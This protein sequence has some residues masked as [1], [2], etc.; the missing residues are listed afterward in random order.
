MQLGQEGKAIRQI[1][2][3]LIMVLL[4]VFLAAPADAITCRG[5]KCG[6]G[7]KFTDNTYENTKIKAA[8]SFKMGGVTKK[9][10]L[11]Y[12]Q[13]VNQ[14]HYIKYCAQRTYCTVNKKCEYGVA[15]PVIYGSWKTTGKYE[16]TN[17]WI[18]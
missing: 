5:T 2:I 13:T 18:A 3:V 14:G 17:Y 8:Y 16:I 15:Y 10:Y 7:V 1:F 4:V 9:L 12:T 6:K 11:E